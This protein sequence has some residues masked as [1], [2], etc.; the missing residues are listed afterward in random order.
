MNS[1]CLDKCVRDANLLGF[2]RGHS[3]DGRAHDWQSC[4]RLGSRV[5]SSPPK[6]YFTLFICSI[7]SYTPANKGGGSVQFSA[8]VASYSHHVAWPPFEE[9]A[10]SSPKNIGEQGCG[11]LVL[12]KRGPRAISK[13]FA[14]DIIGG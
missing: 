12:S 10:G 9:T 14:P 2:Y 5:S 8:H 6:E 4:S 13:P 3:S 7:Q 1:C 11:I